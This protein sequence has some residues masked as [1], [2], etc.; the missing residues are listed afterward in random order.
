MKIFIRGLAILLACLPGSCAYGLAS[1]TVSAADSSINIHIGKARQFFYRSKPDSMFLELAAARTL[2]RHSGSKRGLAEVKIVTGDFCLKN[3]LLG[4]A[5]SSF[6]DALALLD[7]SAASK[8]LKGELFAGLSMVFFRR[9]SYPEALE[10]GRDAVAMFSHAGSTSSLA[11]AYMQL[12][13]ILNRL[14]RSREAEKLILKQA[15]PLFRSAGNTPARVGCFNVLGDLYDTMNRNSEAKWFFI[16]ANT[17]GRSLSNTPAIVE[18]LVKLGKI[19]TR[20]GDYQLAQRDFSEAQSL[21]T[22]GGLL[23]LLSSVH[24]ERSTLYGKTGETVAAEKERSL[25]AYW[26][27]LADRLEKKQAAGALHYVNNFE[28]EPPAIVENKKPGKVAHPMPVKLIWPYIV[29]F[30]L[31]VAA[32]ILILKFKRK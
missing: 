8:V 24:D 25:A 21:A 12:S 18:S 30:V 15:L 17:L 16:Q 5:D 14:N 1:E 19:K 23:S 20:I 27:R 13:A 3:S 32:I 28:N 7:T 22:S 26:K 10:Y 4:R 2:S 11:Q 31:I 29:I 9:R 6:R